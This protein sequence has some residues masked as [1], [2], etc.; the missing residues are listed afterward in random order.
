[1][2]LGNGHGPVGAASIHDYDFIAFRKATL[3]DTA[4]QEPL[5]GRISL[6][7]RRLQERCFLMTLQLS[8]ILLTCQLQSLCWLP[9]SASKVK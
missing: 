4:H 8:Q 9:R 6:S 1:M 7:C 3:E 2:L 5:P